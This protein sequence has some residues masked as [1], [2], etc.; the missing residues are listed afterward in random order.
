LPGIGRIGCSPCLE[1]L[2]Q[3]TS[4]LQSIEND[5]SDPQSKTA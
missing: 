1:I 2:I 5:K 3:R 4:T